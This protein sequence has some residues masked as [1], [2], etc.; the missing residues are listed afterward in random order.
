MIVFAGL[1]PHTPLL[2]PTIGKEFYE[3]LKLTRNALE[4][5]EQTLYL[6]KPQLI[7]VISAHAGIF[8]EAF[9]INAHTTLTSSYKEL[10]DYTTIQTWNG[11]PSFAT[12]MKEAAQKK[13]ISTQLV[14]NPIID[15]GTSIPLNYLTSHLPDIEI[16][17]IGYT[18]K[19]SKDHVLFGQIMQDLCMDSDKRIA[20]IASGDLSHGLTSDAPAGFRKSGKLFDTRIIE[21][22]ESHNTTGITMLDEE[23]VKD[24]AECGYRSLLILLGAIQNMNHT[25]KN[26]AYEHPFGVGYLTGEFQFA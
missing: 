1:T 13:H 22:L 26:L 19:S 25:F 10:G 5:L 9:T 12:Q 20:I 15:Y 3:K 11:S 17:S 7:I 21:M 14:S 4:Q 2:L 23:M 24:A 6:K 18:K 16:V 8:E